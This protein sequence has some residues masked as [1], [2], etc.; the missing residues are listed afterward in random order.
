MATKANL[1]IDQGATFSTTVTVTDDE[2][3][4]MN[5]SGYT[6]AA[7]IRKHYTSSNSVNFSVSIAGSDGE[8]TLGLTAN[9][10]SLISPG[11]Y[12]YDC[13]ITNGNGI[14]SRILEGIVTVTPE[15][16]R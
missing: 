9:A 5:L 1:L 16:T 13:E 7:Q 12:V 15:V 4:A 11:R 3:I 2:G 14:V 6:G 10:T 8:V